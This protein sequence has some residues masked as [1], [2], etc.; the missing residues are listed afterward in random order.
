MVVARERLGTYHP[1]PFKSELPKRL[2]SPRR[3]ASQVNP[4]A[5]VCVIA[6]VG[7][8]MAL[9]YLGLRGRALSLEYQLVRTRAELRQLEIANQHL[10]LEAGRLGSLAHIELAARTKLGMVSP[11]EVKF[12]V[13]ARPRDSM[14]ATAR[15]PA[16]LG[17]REPEPSP[18]L[19]SAVAEWI[20][21]VATAV[22]AAARLN[23]T[24]SAAGPP[25]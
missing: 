21:K 19:A 12:V 20:G 5:G 25:L 11:K 10:E 1:V 4:V 13:K 8:A 17:S 2:P 7:V 23:D 6:L 3:T 16:V 24:G 9:G 14:L 18:G 22:T 15:P